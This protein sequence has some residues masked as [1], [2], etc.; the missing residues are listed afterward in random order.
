MSKNLERWESLQKLDAN[1]TPEELD[2]D[3]KLITEAMKT[4]TVESAKERK[5]SNKARPWWTEELKNANKRR[6]RL[7]V[8]QRTHKERTGTQS[9]EINCEIRKVT[10]YFRRLYKYEKAKW[11][12]DTLEETTPDKMWGLKEWSK[13]TRNYP[14]PVIKKQN[15]EMAVEHEDKCDALREALFKSPPCL[16]NNDEPNLTQGQNHDLEHIKIT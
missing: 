13:G 9:A 10:N 5:P 6:M 14:S 1:H 15:G 3:V 4:A 8:D 2:T 12:K 11:I 16:E 7:R